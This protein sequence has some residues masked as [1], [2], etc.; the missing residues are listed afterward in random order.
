MSETE[1]CPAPPHAY[2]SPAFSV[3]CADGLFCATEASPIV[4][5]SRKLV[6]VGE[7]MTPGKAAQPAIAALFVGNDPSFFGIEAAGLARISQA[8]AGP[9]LFSIANAPDSTNT[10]RPVII[11]EHVGVN[12]E[13]AVFEETPIP[14]ANASQLAAPLA[15]AG[16][17]LHAKESAKIMYDVAAQMRNLH[18]AGLY[19]QD[20]RFANVCVRR[21]GPNPTDIRATLVDHELITP[22]PYARATA[23]AR[24]YEQT[25]F[26]TLP[27]EIRTRAGMPPNNPVQPGALMRDLAYLAALAFE[28]STGKPITCAH[29]DS[30]EAAMRSFFPKTPMHMAP[31]SYAADGRPLI[32]CLDAADLESLANAAGLTPISAQLFFDPA[33]GA[34]LQQ[35]ALFERFADSCDIT[36]MQQ[37]LGAWL[38]VDVEF[39]ARNI[40]YPRWVAQCRAEGREPE[41]PNYNSQ[42]KILRESN[43]NQ[44]LDIPAKMHALGYRIVSKNGADP[45]RCETAF[46]NTEVEYLAQREHERWMQERLANGWKWAAAR[47]DA[48]R[49]HPDLLP[50]SQLP[51]ALKDYDRDAVR[52]VIDILNA[53]NL[54]ITR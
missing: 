16:T 41:Y 50:Y 52:G 32:R 21:F 35:N 30:A 15:K 20:V 46:S 37:E 13:R 8:G 3:S 53:A 49:E 10:P 28:L 18:T 1:Q 45:A 25:L 38:H 7:W 24:P 27:A 33:Q 48:A 44:I 26:A 54:T 34:F 5:S 51:E 11:S 40:V 12:L 47:N 23:A 22:H 43:K 6:Y 9:R 36:R 31:F 14:G 29:A 39:I 4:S 2:A 42:P 19:H 17:P